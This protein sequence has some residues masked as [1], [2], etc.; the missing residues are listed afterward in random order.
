M[1]LRNVAD[2]RGL[3]LF[4]NIFWMFCSKVDGVKSGGKGEF[5]LRVFIIG[6]F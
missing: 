2:L 3:L 5:I 4:R 1:F 6:R